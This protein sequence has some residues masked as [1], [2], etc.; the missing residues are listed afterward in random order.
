[1]ATAVAIGTALSG[2]SKD[3][4]R[5]YALPK[6][7]CGVTVNPDLM[8]PFLPPGKKIATQ[9]ESPNGGTKRCKVSVDGEVSLI[10]GQ[11]WWEKGGTVADVASVNARVDPGQVTDNEKYLYSGT[12]AV[13]KA[14]GCTDA[15]HPDQVLF[16]VLQV[17]TSGQDD[18]AT[19]KRLIVDYT[20]QLQENNKCV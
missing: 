14:E 8:S 7:L 3:E 12:G 4:E 11:L 1:M 9:Q 5:E 18:A 17:F 16:T 13:G 20:E 15:T 10:A 19:M 6:S 2:C